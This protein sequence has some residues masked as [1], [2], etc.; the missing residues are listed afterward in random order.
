MK[1]RDLMKIDSCD[2]AIHAGCPIPRTNALG[3]LA[4]LCDRLARSE[5]A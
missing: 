2:C 5:T 3:R 1:A 4:L